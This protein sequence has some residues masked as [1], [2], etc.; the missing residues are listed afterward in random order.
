MSW[1]EEFAS[2]YE[3]WSAHMTADVAVYVD[4]A[5]EADGPL[6]ELAIGNGR[7]DTG[8]PGHRT[9]RDRHRHLA[10][11]ARKGAGRRGRGGR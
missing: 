7:V 10:D 11:D 6:V 4:L 2:R 3:E 9:K 5:R 1:D 8:R